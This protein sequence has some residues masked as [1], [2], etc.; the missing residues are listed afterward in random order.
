MFVQKSSVL[1]ND[2]TNRRPLWVLCLLN[3]FG[4]TMVD[5]VTREHTNL[6]EWRPAAKRSCPFLKI[7]KSFDWLGSG[8]SADP[9]L[10]RPQRAQKI[11]KAVTTNNNNK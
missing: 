6:R 10:N 1:L 7:F 9:D 8:D 2:L 4:A 3:L 11:E 5:V